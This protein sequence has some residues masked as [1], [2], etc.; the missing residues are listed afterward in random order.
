MDGRPT[1]R[2]RPSWRR[3]LFR[4]LVFLILVAGGT[5]AGLPWLLGTAPGRRALEAGVN[6]VLAPSRVKIGGLSASW[7]KPTHVSGLVLTNG[8]GKTLIRARQAVIG[9]GLLKLATK[10]MRLGTIIVE[11]A[12]VDI[13]RRADG[14]IDLVDALNPPG[15]AP[16]ASEASESKAPAAPGEPLD[17]TLHVVRGTLRLKSPEL[18]APVEAGDLDLLVNLPADSTKVLNWKIRLGSPAGSA[19]GK[20]ETLALDGTYDHRAASDPD[21]TLHV[22]GERWPL[23]L[24]GASFGADAVVKARLDGLVLLERKGGKYETSGDATLADVDAAGPVLGGDRVRLSRVVAGWDLGQP[25]SGPSGWELRRMA[26]KSDVGEVSGTGSLSEDGKTPVLKAE[27]NLNLAALASQLPRL[28][29]L[30]E[31]I[32]LERGTAQIHV[33]LAAE[34]EGQRGEVLAK[35]SD[36][37]AR[38]A[39]HAFT[40]GAPATLAARATKT[41]TGF[42]VQTLSVKSAFLSVESSGDLDRGLTLKGN[43]DLGGLQAQLRE[44]VDF[45]GV[46]LA[47]K[48]TMAADYRKTAKGPS[49]PGTRPRSRA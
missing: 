38:D 33:D 32:T 15:P 25:A 6:R 37:A 10:P 19:D 16:A 9:Q 48:G 40:L 44:A 21:L 5:F 46:T 24:A 35:I 34:G 31:G 47:G 14:S 1:P 41:P 22:K 29:H 39:R 4:G 43:L 30:R 8:E 18:A 17:V 36:L 42:N 2:R 20:D 3:R 45:G 23:T 12:D 27:A 49:S 7:F 13:E 28:L 11:G 26:V